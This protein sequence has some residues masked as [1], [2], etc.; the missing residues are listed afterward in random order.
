MM[1]LLFSLL[2]IFSITLSFGQTI[3]VA[4]PKV[5]TNETSSK[6]TERD[7]LVNII[8]KQSE[9]L[10]A[11]NELLT[12]TLNANGN[13]FG[14]LSTYFTLISIL[15]SIIVIAL[16]LINFFFVLK[17]S[18]ESLLR[19]EKLEIDLP[20]KL[21][22]EFGQYLESFEKRKA[23]Q[24]I[25]SLSNPSN[26]NQVVN[27]F[28]LS[29][30]SDFDDED[31]RTVIKF[32]QEN[33]EIE[34]MDRTVLNSILKARPSLIAE[35]YY[36]SII[37]NEE[38]EDFETA[39]DYLISNNPEQNIRFWEI[40]IKASE[41]G[42]NILMD[43]FRNI[44]TS[45]L[46]NPFDKKSPDKKSL[47]ETLVKLFFN[48]QIICDA[49][50]TKDLSEHFKMSGD[51]NVNTINWNPFLESTIYIKKHFEQKSRKKNKS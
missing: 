31:Q 49:V 27:F 11:N 20:K 38:K 33:K 4:S 6:I 13:I 41:N 23:K 40:I 35:N 26:L 50:E 15:I 17:P 8:L 48:N 37:Q 43:I 3:T 25:N 28:F 5:F 45:Y 7:S 18:K 32:L 2:L 46:G 29:S 10:K 30:F 19:L 1:K 42:H 9:S 12:N 47:G 44:F 22:A 24:L 21:E 34:S 16:P 51:I 14:G 39:I 36:K